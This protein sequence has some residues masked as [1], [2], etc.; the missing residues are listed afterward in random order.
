MTEALTVDAPIPDPLTIL[1]TDPGLSAEIGGEPIVVELVAVGIPGR[2]GADG[3]GVLTAIAGHALS[4]HRAVRHDS[5]GLLVHADQGSGVGALVVGVSEGA[6]AEGALAIAQC[7]GPIT[8]PSWDWAEGCIFLGADGLL[9]QVAPSTGYLVLVG[10]SA[11]PNQM[12]VAP[13][14][15][16]QL[17]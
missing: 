9:T 17:T 16:A 5:E 2:D 10:Y 11:G 4:G 14:I 6:A 12:V 1:A 7:V 3:S 13:R 8:E 15:I